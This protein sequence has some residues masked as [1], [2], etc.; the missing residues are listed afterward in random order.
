MLKH[1]LLLYNLV[2]ADVRTRCVLYRALVCLMCLVSSD[3][4]KVGIDGAHWLIHLFNAYI[5]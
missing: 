4:Y 1:V 2:S 3:S 5:Y